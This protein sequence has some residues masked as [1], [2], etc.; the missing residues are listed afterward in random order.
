MAA[1]L[2]LPSTPS[3]A[4]R[5]VLGPGI[6][7]G[8][9]EMDRLVVK[10]Y[11]NGSRAVAAVH[12]PRGWSLGHL[13][14]TPRPRRWTWDDDDDH[15]SRDQTTARGGLVRRGNRDRAGH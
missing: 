2:G 15:D 5:A 3:R 9:I 13:G 8:R 11:P 6:A 1:V 10:V 4:A 14:W 12:A 7:F